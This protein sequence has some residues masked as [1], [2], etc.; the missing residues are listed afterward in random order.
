MV[1]LCTVV[2]TGLE[3]CFV[4]VSQG[5]FDAIGLAFEIFGVFRLDRLLMGRHSESDRLG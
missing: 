5:V 2:M 3:S 4:I 1:E